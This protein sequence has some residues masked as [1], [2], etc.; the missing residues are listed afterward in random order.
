MKPS[1][2]E[3]RSVWT[4]EWIW[5]SVQNAFIILIVN[6]IDKVTDSDT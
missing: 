4:S 6:Q 2:K 1:D 3:K 5:K